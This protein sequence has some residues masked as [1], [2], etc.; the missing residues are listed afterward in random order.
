MRS[1]YEI[2]NLPCDASVAEIKHAYRNMAK[3]FHPDV[4]KEPNAQ[5]KFIEITE[6]YENL[7]KNKNSSGND[8]SYAFNY[9]DEIMEMR[10]QA[11]AYVKEQE[12]LRKEKLQN[13][14]NR[15]Y[16]SFNYVNFIFIFINIILIIDFF[17][18]AQIVDDEIIGYKGVYE[19]REPISTLQQNHLKDILITRHYSFVVEKNKVERI[20]SR[21][22]NIYFTPIF[23]TLRKIQTENRHGG[24]LVLRPPFSIYKTFFYLIPALFIISVIYYKTSVFNENKLTL[25][26]VNCFIIATQVVVYF[27]MQ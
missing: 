18:P 25:A 6:A 15:I 22:A 11:W 3:K 27:S 16:G 24:N 20:G 9:E 23:K 19:T 14:L 7:V 1:D 4:N 8:L 5:K 2:L 21:E 13:L 12:R 17:I 26:I 10:K